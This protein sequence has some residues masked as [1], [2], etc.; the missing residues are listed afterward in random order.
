[1]NPSPKSKLLDDAPVQ[2]RDVVV[3]GR[4]NHFRRTLCYEADPIPDIF[5]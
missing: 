3:A 5:I 1:M 4:R 2:G